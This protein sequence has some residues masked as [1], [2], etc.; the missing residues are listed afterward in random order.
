MHLIMSHARNSMSKDLELSLREHVDLYMESSL[1]LKKFYC[2]KIIE[3]CF[4]LTFLPG[5]SFS[6]KLIMIS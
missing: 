4:A 5:H 3:N 6:Y 2:P 1:V